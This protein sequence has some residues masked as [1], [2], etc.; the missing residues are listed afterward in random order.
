M[1]SNDGEDGND[2]SDGKVKMDFG[3]DQDDHA[4]FAEMCDLDCGE[5]GHCEGGVCVCDEGWRGRKEQKC[6]HNFQIQSVPK[7]DLIGPAS[8]VDWKNS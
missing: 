8:R 2:Q 5:R 3:A 7:I 4:D 1:I 6:S